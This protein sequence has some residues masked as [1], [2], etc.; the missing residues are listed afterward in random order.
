VRDPTRLALGPTQA[1]LKR[2]LM[3]EAAAKAAI[4][5]PARWLLA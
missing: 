5:I 4:A 1:N 2:R 3:L